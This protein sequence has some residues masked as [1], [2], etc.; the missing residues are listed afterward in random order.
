MSSAAFAVVVNLSLVFGQAAATPPTAEEIDAAIL[1]L[2]DDSFDVRQK[3]TEWLW[4]AGVAVEPQLRAALKSTDPE[5]R[6]RAASVLDKVRYGLRPDTPPDVAV[7]IDQFRH[8]G[9]VGLRRQAL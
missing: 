2:G 1:R 4:Q 8:G 7:L 9:S 5:I 6:T 3:A